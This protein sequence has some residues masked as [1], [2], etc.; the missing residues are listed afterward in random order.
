[1]HRDNYQ[2]LEMSQLQKNSVL[3]ILI[4][5]LFNCVIICRHSIKRIK[6]IFYNRYHNINHHNQM[7]AIIMGGWRQPHS[8]YVIKLIKWWQAGMTIDFTLQP[9]AFGESSYAQIIIRMM[10]WCLLLSCVG[11]YEDDS[12]SQNDRFIW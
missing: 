10:Q 5:K 12:L 4:N 11:D 6:T 2:Y 8:P 3:N 1:M 9:V 7:P